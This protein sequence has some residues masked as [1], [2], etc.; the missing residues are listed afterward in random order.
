[1]A[2]KGEGGYNINMAITT[3]Y[4]GDTIRIKGMFKNTSNSLI[5]A[6][7]NLVTFTVYSYETKRSLF[8]GSATKLSTGIYY[9]DYEVP[10]SETKY[11]VELKG[12]FDGY[13]QLARSVIKAKF[14]I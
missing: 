8:T 13:P 12:D 7:G 2:F 10:S 4:T 3:V 9:Y 1:M 6:D 5:D 11:I 14:R